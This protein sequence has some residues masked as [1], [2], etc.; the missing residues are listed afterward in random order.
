MNMQVKLLR[1]LQEKEV[2]MVGDSRPRKV[3]VRVVAATNKN[4]QSLIQSGAFRE[5]L[6]Y[7]LNVVT[8]EIPPLRDREK[9]ILL[10]A[11]HFVRKFALELG[12]SVPKFSPKALQVLLKYPWPGNVRE[13]ENAVQ[14]IIVMSDADIIEVPDL[15]VQT[16][17][18]ALRTARLDRSL[19]EVESEHIR[20]VLVK[21]RGNKSRASEILGIDRKTL[22][23]KMRKYHIQ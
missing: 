11:Q 20:N 6:F 9:D 10:L 16:R 12:R 23:E 1:V 21:E 15:P 5:E 4:L 14:R 13:L 8:L 17:F 3:N 7:R 18:S 22:R 2:C 19:S